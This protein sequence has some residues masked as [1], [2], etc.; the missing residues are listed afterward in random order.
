MKDT[1]RKVFAQSD[2]MIDPHTACGV[3]V[4]NQMDIVADNT[5]CLSTAHPAKFPDV[6]HEV[7]GAWPEIPDGLRDLEE[8]QKVSYKIMPELQDL[9]SFI[10]QHAK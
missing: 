9:K 7:L 6:I 3:Y 10:S 5:V 2:Y 4:A 1:I 8:R